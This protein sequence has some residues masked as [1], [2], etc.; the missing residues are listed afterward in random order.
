MRKKR[1]GLGQG[2]WWELGQNGELWPT[3]VQD[4]ILTSAL[5]YLWQNA[6]V[7]NNH[8]I[9]NLVTLNQ[10]AQASVTHEIQ[11]IYSKSRLLMQIAESDF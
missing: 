7:N 11:G 4:Q 8:L 6:S 10:A 2:C 5:T 1:S 9:L 3:K